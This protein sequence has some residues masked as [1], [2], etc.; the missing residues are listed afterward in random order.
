[1]SHDWTRQAERGSP[2]M[3]HLIRWIAMHLG[4][5]PARLLLYPITLYFLIFAPV[6]RRASY[7]YLERVTGSPVRW[8]HV[9]KHIHHFAA[10]ILDRV[11]LLSGRLEVLD[12]RLHHIELVMDTLA[13][14]S[15]CLLLGSHLGS[16]EVLRAL[17]LTRHD[18]PLKVLMHESHNRT[19]TDILHTINP[20]IAETVIPLGNTESLLT[21][22]EYVQQGYFLGI[23]GD[24][25]F[26][27]EKSTHCE[28]LGDSAAFPTGPM[29]V[30]SLLETPVILFFGLY[31]GGR[32]YNIYFEKLTDRVVVDR[33]SRNG[34]LGMWT[35][36]Y[37]D[38]LAF[39]ARRSPYN[40]FNFYDFWNAGG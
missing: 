15:G 14:G 23:L 31:E 24:R 2:V 36:K 11:F 5:M 9:A 38:R 27:R 4:R 40:W 28:F 22:Y 39:H 20:G 37:A 7:G 8:W 13:S 17:A 18:F 32:C 35:Q 26:D 1:M 3:L 25:V 33:A 34:D 10:T 16:F 21:A 29:L 19:I 30:A 6:A 12:I